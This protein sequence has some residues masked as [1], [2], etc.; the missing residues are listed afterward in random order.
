M[1]KFKETD[2]VITL[3]DK[4]KVKKGTEGVVVMVYDDPNEAYEVEFETSTDTDWPM[5]VFLPDEI[6]RKQ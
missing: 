4:P 3:V 2:K 5:E 1:S 6:A